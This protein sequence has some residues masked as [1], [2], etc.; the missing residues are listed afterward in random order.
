MKRLVVCTVAFC[1]AV[2]IVLPALLVLAGGPRER[3]DLTDS[4]II[5]NVLMADSGQ[6][7]KMP[8]D[9]YLVGVVAAE[10]PAEFDL[11]ALKAQAVAAR[12]QV[13]RRMRR[14]GGPG[15][16]LHPQADVCTDSRHCQ[17]WESIAAMQ[18]KWHYTEFFAYWRKITRAVKETDGVIVCYQGQPI[19][20]V[21][22]STCGG[23]TENAGDVWS[24]DIP[25]LKA[26][27]CDTDRHS[28]YF[29]DRAVFTLA[30]L[31]EKLG[32]TIRARQVTTQM[33]GGR[34]IKVM[35]SPGL[36]PV[37]EVMAQTRTGRVKTARVGDRVFAATE[38][39]N[40][41][42]LRSTRFV[43]Q[44]VG[45][46]VYIKTQGYG[47]GVGMCQYGADGMAKKGLGYEDILKHYYT[48]VTVEH[49][50]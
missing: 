25:Y 44:V 39:R 38:L 40:A 5:V 21:F 27:K 19:D 1:F 46:K 48:G 42:G 23:M 50:W 4:T 49:W 43:T 28:P 33:A 6:I 13:V 31:E 35:A 45:D 9:E 12:T 29:Q 2:V 37:I 22:H 47:H 3:N 18:Q 20:A 26:V 11:E 32:A 36:E 17:A 10:M 7:V 15:C 16:D 30:E 8:L 14:L 41:L 34:E 24:Q